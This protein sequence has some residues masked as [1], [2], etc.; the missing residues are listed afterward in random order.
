MLA[1]AQPTLFQNETRSASLDRRRIYRYELWRQW[2]VEPPRRFVNFV[3][4]NPSTAD[5]NTDDPTVRKAVKFACSWGFDA[6]CITNLFAYRATDPRAMMK[7]ADPV[8]FGND[9]HILKVAREDSLVVCAWGRDGAFMG[10]GSIVRRMLAR[11]DPHYLRLTREQPWHPLYLPDN[12][13]PSRWYSEDYFNNK[14]TK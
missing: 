4:L 5:E 6:L 3:C 8:G 10:R 11:F 13:R 14:E 12:T 9:R 7:A 1:T 2:T